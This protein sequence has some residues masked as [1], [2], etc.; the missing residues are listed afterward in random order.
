MRAVAI[1]SCLVVGCFNP[2]PQA[3]APCGTNRECPDGLECNADNRCEKPGSTGD[4]APA[5]ACVNAVCDGD[6]LIGCGATDVCA[7][8]CSMEGEPHC[9]QLAPSNGITL[10]HLAGAT[11]NVL[12]DRYVFDSDDGSIR[13]MNNDVRLPVANGVDAGIGFYIVNGVGVFTA[14]SFTGNGV[15]TVQGGRP[16]AFFARTN[17]VVAT[18]ISGLAGALSIPGPGGTAANASTAPSGCRG[19]AGRSNSTIGAEYGEGGGGGGGAT[20]GGNGGASNQA[21]ATGLG[22]PQ[23]TTPSTIPLR[24]GH[25]GGNG[26]QSTTHDGGGGGGAIAFVALDTVTITGA[27]SAG[28]GGGQVQLAVG[29]GGGGGGGGAIFVEAPT[30]MI[31]G[32]LTANG[33]AGAAPAGTADGPNGSAATAT[34]AVGGLYSC[35]ATVGGTPTNVRGG[36]GAAGMS[37]PTNGASCTRSDATPVVIASQGGGGGGAVGRIEVKSKFG[38][39]SGLA[40]P[41]ATN[42]MPLFE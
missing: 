11:A 20:A 34:P 39:V 24:G 15:W 35:V 22:G 1:A 36:N 27:I 25:G 12:V 29:G 13:M 4:A 7:H 19:R 9:R 8:G 18:S 26:G 42:S 28:G 14:N 16:I 31:T 33:G 5:D 2:S 10:A 41:T 40:S 3:G 38:G 21:G 6:M 32:Q 17:I 23:C 37:A 30:V